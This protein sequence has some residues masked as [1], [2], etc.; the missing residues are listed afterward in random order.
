VFSE[1]E[2]AF[3]VYLKTTSRRDE[4]DTVASFSSRTKAK[5]FLD[6]IRKI[7]RMT[8]GSCHCPAFANSPSP[9]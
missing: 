4:A 6:W 9:T 3:N 8:I 5:V 1:P 2:F 7:I